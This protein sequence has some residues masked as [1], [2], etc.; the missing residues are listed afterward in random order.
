MI[1]FL[2]KVLTFSSSW[3]FSHDFLH[4]VIIYLDFCD[5]LKSVPK[6]PDPGPGTKA[7]PRAHGKVTLGSLAVSLL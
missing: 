2:F 3:T 7:G 6:V 1:L 4:L 5:P